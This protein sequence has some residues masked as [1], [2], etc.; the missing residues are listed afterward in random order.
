MKHKVNFTST[1]VIKEADIP[2]LWLGMCKV[3]LVAYPTL[4]CRRLAKPGR[5]MSRCHA[6]TETAVS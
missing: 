6:E 3:L 1:E 4:L 5:N 2:G